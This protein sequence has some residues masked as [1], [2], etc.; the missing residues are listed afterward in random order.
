[1]KLIRLGAPAMIVGAGLMLFMTPSFG[2]PEFMKKEKGSKCVTC[3][4]GAGKKEINDVGKCYKAN[5]NKDLDKCK[6]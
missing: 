5:G 3:H 2:K 4:V 6:T 1:M